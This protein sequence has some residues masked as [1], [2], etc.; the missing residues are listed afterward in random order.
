MRDAATLPDGDFVVLVAGP[1]ED[2]LLRVT[3]NRT[4]SVLAHNFGEAMDRGDE[5][6]N[7]PR[8]AVGGTPPSILVTVNSPV[9]GVAVLSTNG[10]LLR[11]LSLGNEYHGLAVERGSNRLYLLRQDGQIQAYQDFTVIGLTSDAVA[12]LPAGVAG[13]DL[14]YSVTWWTDRPTL[15]AAGSDGHLYRVSLDGS[16]VEKVAASGCSGVV[17]LD[18]SGNAGVMA[19][20]ENGS[21][22]ALSVFRAPLQFTGPVWCSGSEFHHRLSGTIGAYVSFEVSSD[23]VDWV[24]TEYKVLPSADVDFFHPLEG[25]ASMFSRA[26]YEY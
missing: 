3:T 21:L 2:V 19:Q 20:D 11:T 22:Q 7:F 9:R 13:R 17:G 16:S 8:V 12:S 15:L 24:K 10:V 14:A 4:V 23:L 26:A 5:I 18:V 25:R 6:S 1:G